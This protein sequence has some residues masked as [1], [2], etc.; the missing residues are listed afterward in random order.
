VRYRAPSIWQQYRGAVLSA[1]G[2]LA[3]QSLLILGLLHQRRARQRAEN[4]SRR[5]LA[6]AAD[7]RRCPR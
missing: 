6:L 7:A 4:D 3:V 2:V 1:V 5:S